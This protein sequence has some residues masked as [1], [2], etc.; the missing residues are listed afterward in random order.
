MTQS[1]PQLHPTGSSSS[2]PADLSVAA[3]GTAI[4][5]GV[6]PTRLLTLSPSRALDFMT[7]PLR[8]RFRVID[9]LPEPPT[10]ATAR[11][12][13]VHAVLERLF[14]AAA[15]D[16][17]PETALGLVAAEWERLVSEEPE[18][19]EAASAAIA[20][21]TWTSGIDELL[22][23]YFR[24]EDPRRLNP[25]AREIRVEADFDGAMTL[26]GYI[27]RLDEAA[28]GELRIV[29]YKTG[30]APQEAFEG[31]ALFQLKF[32]ALVLWR[33]RGVVAKELRLIYLSGGE[34]L[35]YSPDEAELQRFE[36]TVRALWQAIDRAIATGDWRPRVSK[37]CD[38]CNHQAL[39][40]A[41]GG[42]TPPLP[43]RRDIIL[44][45]DPLLVTAADPVSAGTV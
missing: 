33:T 22:R 10:A 14:D 4:S 37:L 8:Y 29:D 5:D 44:E 20:D 19:A 15:G 41:F 45:N 34:L 36:R 21:G 24:L 27:D 2:A 17:T 16:R 3:A 40:P 26:T 7:C 30:R 6:P 43:G 9:R 38:W 32:Y 25:A 31:K 28:T 13:L 23:T 39:C 35:S 1:P 18:L 42:T 11:G 12:T